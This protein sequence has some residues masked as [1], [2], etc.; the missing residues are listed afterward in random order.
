[1]PRY[2]HYAPNPQQHP[3]AY[4]QGRSQAEFNLE[5]YHKLRACLLKKYTV[6]EETPD[7][8]LC[9]LF[10]V[11]GIDF[12]EYKDY[13]L[14]RTGGMKLRPNSDG[15]I[16][17][18]VLENCHGYLERYWK[19]SEGGILYAIGEG[20]EF[21]CPMLNY[22]S[23]EGTTGSEEWDR[24]FE[25]LKGKGF[26]KSILPCMV[27][28][29]CS[30]TPRYHELIFKHQYFSRQ[31]GCLDATCPFLHDEN[32]F[33]GRRE[34]LLD[35]RREEMSRPTGHQMVYKGKVTFTHQIISKLLL[36]YWV[37]KNLKEDET[38]LAFCANPSCSKVWLEKD[39][40]CPLKACSKCKW[41]YYC[42]VRLPLSWQLTFYWSSVL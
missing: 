34:K 3:E 36:R 5:R 40:E 13:K 6:V 21:Y 12:S 17:K 31:S 33:R 39:A 15:T 35:K 27:C 26:P 1:M 23:H 25:E 20:K 41:T 30:E 11:Q 7:Y 4:E 32:Y 14:E 28:A 29:R 18:D 22:H 8:K 19:C 38:A 9:Q 16:E 37:S 10:P 42:S 24:I 2:N